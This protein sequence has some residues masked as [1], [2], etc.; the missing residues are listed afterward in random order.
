MIRTASELSSADIALKSPLESWSNDGERAPVKASR[1]S[2]S[3]QRQVQY[4][5]ERH[6]FEGN[7]I[8]QLFIML[9]KKEPSWWKGSSAHAMT[10]ASA[11]ASP[12]SSPNASLK[13]KTK[14]DDDDLT[15]ISDV[16]IPD[17]IVW[18]NNIPKGWFY[19]DAKEMQV[20]RKK[21]ETKQVQQAFLRD[22]MFENDIVATCYSIPSNNETEAVEFQFITA[23]QLPIF[24]FESKRGKGTSILQRYVFSLG[25]NKNDMMQVV[26]S[27]VV[28]QVSRRQCVNDLFDERLSPDE[29]CGTFEGPTHQSCDIQCTERLQQCVRNLCRVIVDHFHATDTKHVLSRIVMYLKIAHNSKLILLFASSA[30]VLPKS[31]QDILRSTLLRRYRVALEIAT[32]FVPRLSSNHHAPPSS[33]DKEGIHSKAGAAATTPSPSRLSLIEAP[34]SPTASSVSAVQLNGPSTAPPPK[35]FVNN[36]DAK[37]H[38]FVMR[39][40]GAVDERGAGQQTR[41]RSVSR[42]PSLLR[43]ASSLSGRVPVQAIF[44][45]ILSIEEDPAASDDAKK[46]GRQLLDTCV[47]KVGLP[48][49]RAAYLACREAQLVESEKCELLFLKY[50]ELGKRRARKNSMSSWHSAGAGGSSIN[51]GRRPSTASPV[52]SEGHKSIFDGIS[53]AVGSDVEQHLADYV[54]ACQVFAEQSLGQNRE[55]VT[56]LQIVLSDAVVTERSFAQFLLDIAANPSLQGSPNLTF[57]IEPTSSGYVLSVPLQDR[58][59][60]RFQ[61][62]VHSA[63][64]S[65]QFLSQVKEARKALQPPPKPDSRLTSFTGVESP[66]EGYFGASSFGAVAVSVAM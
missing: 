53:V 32:N 49:S 63:L 27:P 47:K 56:P 25:V 52:A 59:S 23:A 44:G 3:R 7:T 19:Y 43:R 42:S 50:A 12:A 45:E 18:E 33:K 6:A 8:T 58:I 17:T 41:S 1:R 38:G 54:Y 34:C 30:R 21:V 26:W 62:I 15:S 24:L 16:I 20:S 51:L 14:V 55:A 48:A 36:S 2:G 5:L 31:Q 46:R 37:K 66:G 9:A 22:A 4:E 13:Q 29:R 57:L 28:T 65:P 35:L 39:T 61:H 60:Q 10:E 40:R 64:A 11:S